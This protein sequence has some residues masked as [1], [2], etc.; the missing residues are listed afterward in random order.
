MSEVA[1]IDPIIIYDRL[2]DFGIHYAKT[3]LWRMEKAERF[4][5]RVKLSP[6]KIGWRK[7]EIRAWLDARDAER[8]QRTG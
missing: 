5:K 2:P 1:E 4:P 6:Y 3:S 8:K 7:S